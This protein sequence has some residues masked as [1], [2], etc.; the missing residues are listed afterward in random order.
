MAE[1]KQ[2]WEDKYE[3]DTKERSQEI[4]KLKFKLR[5]ERIERTK[6]RAENQAVRNAIRALDQSLEEHKDYII[7]LQEDSVR[8]TKEFDRALAEARRDRE[9]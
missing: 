3:A 5:V 1:E 4:T 8:Q 2:A 7:E 6:L 9:D